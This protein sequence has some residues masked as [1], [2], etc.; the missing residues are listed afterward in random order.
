MTC[1][2]CVAT[3]T[4][5]TT[6]FISPTTTYTTTTIYPITLDWQTMLVGKEDV[7]GMGVIIVML[8]IGIIIV[9]VKRR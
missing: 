7:I 2:Y 1:Y 5:T 6:P 8:L 3:T 9:A 4:T